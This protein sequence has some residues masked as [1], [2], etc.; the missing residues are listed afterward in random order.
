MSDKALEIG[1]LL[2]TA[3]LARDGVERPRLDPIWAEARL[4]ESLG[5][6]HIWVGD[7]SRTETA[8]PRADCISMMAGLAIATSKIRIGTVPLS[9]PLRNPVLLGHQLAT[10]D[11]MSNGR[12]VIGVSIGKGGPLGDQEFAACGVPRRER[13][14]RLSE[15]LELMRRLWTEDLVTFEGKFYSL[16]GETGIRPMPI[17]RPIMTYVCANGA[18]AGLRRAGTY[19]DG[20]FCGTKDPERFARMRAVV[21]EAAREAGREGAADRS[22]LFTAIHLDR[23][24]HKARMDATA[25]LD[26]Y[27]GGHKAGNAAN[28][29][30][31]SPEEI[32]EHLQPLID[33]GLTTIC[34]RIVSNDYEGQA[35]LIQKDL[36]PKLHARPLGARVAPTA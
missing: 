12:L 33:R 17:Q 7:S 6:D 9:V 15:S 19:G 35:E 21:D 27:F 2:H 14:A 4:I 11:V 26:A 31:G 23:D 3:S 8:W 10:V 5:Y 25:H 34:A 22:A 28:G 16:P 13:G 36:L 32:A 1:I 24:G 30:F 20:W 18:E 29:Y